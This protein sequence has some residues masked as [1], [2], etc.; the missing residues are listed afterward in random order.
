M[1]NALSRGIGLAVA[2]IFLLSGLA[3]SQESK[4]IK[5]PAPEM[6]GGRPLMEVLKDRQTTRTFA[7]TELP[8]QTLSNL[9]WAAWGY[10]R[11]EKGLRT[12]PSASNQQEID[13]YVAMEKGLY[14]YDAK[15]LELRLMLAKDLRKA[16]GTQRFVGSVPL[17]LIYVADH[18]RMYSGRADEETMRFYSAAN[19]G[20]I[21]QNVYL[22]CA[23]EGL[24]TV[25]RG[26]V[27]REALAKEM[28]LKAGHKVVLCQSVGYRKTSK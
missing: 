2:A 7:E 25:V 21:S 17:N 11:P 8:L 4:S 12:A 28:K 24:G 5:L 16:T 26:L 14:L 6:T 22:Y 1:R 3:V 9:L 10:N 27:D 20:Y 19:A 15:S 13:L 23:S 18:N